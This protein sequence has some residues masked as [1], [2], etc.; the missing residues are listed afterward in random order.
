MFY[1]LFYIPE[2][3]FK[4]SSKQPVDYL[5]QLTSSVQLPEPYSLQTGTVEDI[6]P[7]SNPDSPLV[8]FD[9]WFDL[10][11]EVANYVVSA[12]A[13]DKE[14]FKAINENL[15]GKH[16]VLLMTALHISRSVLLP[17]QKGFQPE[18]DLPVLSLLLYI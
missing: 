4:L 1:S 11:E 7:S 12:L 6:V 8:S 2:S 3:A 10:E 14:E 17:R 18:L 13:P 15:K 5:S 9:V 16:V